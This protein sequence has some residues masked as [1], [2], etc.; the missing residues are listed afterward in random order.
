MVQIIH[1][2][3]CWEAREEFSNFWGWFRSIVE[4]FIE[5]E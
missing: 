4:Y 2:S 3:E 1:A 5:D